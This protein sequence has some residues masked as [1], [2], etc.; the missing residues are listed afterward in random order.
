MLPGYVVRMVGL[1][2]IL[3]EV[4]PLVTTHEDALIGLPAAVHD[5]PGNTVVKSRV[6]IAAGGFV[7]HAMNLAPTVKPRRE[8]VYSEVSGTDTFIA[9]ATSSA[10]TSDKLLPSASSRSSPSITAAAMPAFEA[11]ASLSFLSRVLDAM[12]RHAVT[13]SS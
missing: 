13:G 10:M 1:L 2:H 4:P 11:T 6:F 9:V 3:I 7:P 5:R 12:T 8:S